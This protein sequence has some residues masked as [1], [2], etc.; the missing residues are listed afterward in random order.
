MTWSNG[1]HAYKGKDSGRGKRGMSKIL[2]GMKINRKLLSRAF[3]KLEK[4]KAKP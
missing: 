4:E 3:V 1:R 2:K